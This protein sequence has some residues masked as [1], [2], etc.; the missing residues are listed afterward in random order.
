MLTVGWSSFVA[1]IS[2]LKNVVCAARRRWL[3]LVFE[4]Q[5]RFPV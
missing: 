3:S 5:Y 2:G 1:P 4:T